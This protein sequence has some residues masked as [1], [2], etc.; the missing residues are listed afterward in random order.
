MKFRD[1]GVLPVEDME[2]MT[3]DEYMEW[4]NDYLIYEDDDLIPMPTP[5]QQAYYDALGSQRYRTPQPHEQP[6]QQGSS[7]WMF[8]FLMFVI[9]MAL[10]VAK[11]MGWL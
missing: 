5:K 3:P 8:F 9:G 11:G 10:I 4:L 1:K 2:G 7:A 6:Q